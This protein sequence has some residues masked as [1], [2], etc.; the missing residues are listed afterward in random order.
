MGWVHLPEELKKDI[1]FARSV[2]PLKSYGTAKPIFISFPGLCQGR[3][4]WEDLLA[5]F[6]C[7]K[8][9]YSDCN[10]LPELLRDLPLNLFY[11]TTR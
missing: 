7:D 3:P 5:K 4:V 2:L 9:G 8:A 10:N 11:M 1:D 6:N